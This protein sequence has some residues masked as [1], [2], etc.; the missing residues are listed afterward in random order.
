MAG[1]VSAT[2]GARFE[3]PM[4]TVT[5]RTAE[6]VAAPLLSR[7]T[8]VMPY[9]P[10]AM[11]LQVY[12]YGDDVSVA[13]SVAPAWVAGRSMVPSTSVAVAAR[14][15]LAGAIKV[16]PCAGAVRETAGDWLAAG[17]RTVTLSK[18]A[19]AAC[20]GSWLVTSSPTYSV[21]VA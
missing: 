9:D 2:T 15:I 17:M 18:T 5:V 4:E 7:A 14:A 3:D 1:A 11:P 16:A 20:A 19:V 6:V 8:A 10:V 12:A 21:A 13:S